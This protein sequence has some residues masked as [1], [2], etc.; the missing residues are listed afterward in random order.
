MKEVDRMQDAKKINIFKNKNF[1]LLFAGVLVSNVAHVLFNFAISLYVLR[2]ANQAYGEKEA[3]L[4]QALYLA[5]AGIMLLILMPFGGVLA[6]KFN[7]VRTMYITDYIRGIT[8]GLVAV[9]IFFFD[10]PFFML[11][12]LFIMNIIL[13]INSALFN[14]ASSSLLRFIVKDEELQQGSAYLQGS[15][16]LQNIIGLILGGIIYASLGIFWV[17]VINGF[18]YIFS[19]I[20]EMFI[21]YNHLEHTTDDEKMSL[22]LVL[23]DMKSGVKY[24]YHQKAIFATILMALGINFFFSPLFS[25]GIPYFI[26]FGL[27]RE[28]VYLF[29]DFLTPETWYS[30][31]SVSFSVSSV[32][33]ALALSRQKTKEKYG[34]QLKVAI[35]LA[36]TV[37]TLMSIV[38]ILYY[39]NQTSINFTLIGLMTTL[40]M[41]GFMIMLFNIPMNLIIQKNVDPKQLGKVSSVMAVLSQ[42]LIPIGSLVAGVIISQLSPSYLYVFSILGSFVVVF[43]YVRNK[44]ANHI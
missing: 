2:I 17:F 7:K 4:I 3:A 20:S 29:D 40:F 28:P 39:Q 42:A 35:S 18:G 22:K 8:I 10:E 15:Q 31:I 9:I 37:T 23:N 27:A 25:N 13:S 34:K 5:V 24:L 16:N 33:M 43:F 19:A 12:V 30:I 14:P 44:E 36:A 41:T 32:I 38:M 21:K 26:E 6:D 11:I 1:T